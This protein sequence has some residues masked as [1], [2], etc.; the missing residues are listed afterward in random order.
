M[1]H[2][3]HCISDNRAPLSCSTPGHWE[4]CVGDRTTACVAQS[5]EVGLAPVDKVD[6]HCFRPRFLVQTTLVSTESLCK[7][8]LANRAAAHLGVVPG[9]L[10]L[11]NGFILQSVAADDVRVLVQ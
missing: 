2:F 7:G 10:M 8:C 1:D 3:L 9:L 4:A 5:H 11:C 6:V